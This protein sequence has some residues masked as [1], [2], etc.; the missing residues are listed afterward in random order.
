MEVNIPPNPTVRIQSNGR[1][2]PGKYHFVCHRWCTQVQRRKRAT[3]STGETFAGFFG[4]SLSQLVTGQGLQ[5]QKRSPF[6]ACTTQTDPPS[7]TP[8]CPGPPSPSPLLPWALV[9]PFP[10]TLLAQVSVWL[11]SLPF[12]DLNTT[13]S[14]KPS[15]ASRLKNDTAPQNLL[16]SR[17][18]VCLLHYSV[19]PGQGFLLSV[20]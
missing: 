15:L 1:K 16:Y 4:E 11:T 12:L 7:P 17:H 9:C 10:E 5:A 3:P 13:S 18:V 14:G 19:S 2:S 6:A 8:A 20:P